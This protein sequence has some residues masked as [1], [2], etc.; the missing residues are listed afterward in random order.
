MIVTM[1]TM[2]SSS[3]HTFSAHALLVDTNGDIDTCL[4]LGA[5]FHVTPH[6]EGFLLIQRGLA[7]CYPSRGQLCI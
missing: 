1:G 6:H 5:S 7:W 2:H 4:I 3:F